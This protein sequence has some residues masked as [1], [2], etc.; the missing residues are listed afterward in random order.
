MTRIIERSSRP[1][2]LVA[3]VFALLACSLA[4][5]VLITETFDRAE[6]FFLRDVPSGPTPLTTA[7]LDLL[8]LILA[9]TALALRGAWLS[10]GGCLAAG[11]L[12]LAFGV[13][14][15]FAGDRRL[16]LNGG[17]SL[18]IT[19]L[20]GWA[21]VNLRVPRA[22]TLLLVPL[23]LAVCAAD[24]VKCL[25]QSGYEFEMT[26]QQWELHKQELAASGV[27][28]A[29]PQMID[30]ERRLASAEAFG[31][32]SHPNVAAALL[33][34]GLLLG[35]GALLA[36]L[37]GTCGSGFPFVPGAVCLLLGGGIWSTGSLAGGASAGLGV[38]LLAGL[39]GWR[40]SAATTRRLLI[41]AYLAGF[42]LLLGLGLARGGLPGASLDFRWQ[43]WTG[44]AGVVA[45]A[46][47]TG[48]GRL[49]FGPRYLAHRPAAATEAVAD[50]HNVWVAVLAEWGPLGLLG[51]G[52]LAWLTIAAL[53]RWPV[54]DDQHEEEPAG[55]SV[56]PLWWMLAGVPLLH[57]L[58]SGTPLLAPGVGLLWAIELV[59][60]F[61]GVFVLLAGG[62]PHLAGQR[63]RAA[64]GRGI[65][66]AVWVNLV[67][68]LVGFSLMTSG[69][70]SLLV[71]ACVAGIA[72]RGG[73]WSP[74]G[75]FS[76]LFAGLTVLLAAVLLAVVVLPTA[77]SERAYRAARQAGQ[78][79]QVRASAAAL[80]AADPLDPRAP[81]T[82]AGQLVSLALHPR[83]PANLRVELLREA[84]GYAARSVARDPRNPA[85]SQMQ[86][87][88]AFEL[89]RGAADDVVARR[90]RLQQA[91]GFWEQTIER[92]PQAARLRLEAARTA[93]ALYRQQGTERAGALARAW[94]S[95][96]LEL[97]ALRDAASTARLTEAEL[98]EVADLRA[99]VTGP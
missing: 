70:L 17:S 25:G 32:Q 15:G 72:L 27:D 14:V 45:E 22:W 67:H 89:A 11:L 29:V 46:P 26:R 84:E 58:F 60:V 64:L 24:A 73:G 57:V 53:L 65:V 39:H 50:P 61:A 35:L 38:L 34:I 23:V 62:M 33:T 83:A 12:V 95:R 76:P 42:G 78:L 16:A 28:V 68:N 10:R 13:S 1:G 56:G 55:R 52:L 93:V 51:A 36:S 7:L 20:A 4:V 77:R 96:A 5:R 47:L 8:V 69:G 75:R 79:E 91:L 18:L 98:A 41:A 97:H 94:L 81:R 74:G 90:L 37:S 48:V 80:A 2:W 21:L 6:P 82:A 9:G 59:V 30:Y 88:I 3:A 49:N 54:V 66:V 92:N 86:A 43:Y 87:R 19:L 63:S 99:Q 85:G 40:A 71:L 31:Y 44:A